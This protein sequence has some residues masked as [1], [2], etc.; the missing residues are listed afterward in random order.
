M[1]TEGSYRLKLG[2]FISLHSWF[3]SSITL[4][5]SVYLQVH[6]LRALLRLHRKEIPRHGRCDS[7]T[8][9]PFSSSCINISPTESTPLSCSLADQGIKTRIRKDSRVRK[10]PM[11]VL[12]PPHPI[13]LSSAPLPT[14]SSSNGSSGSQPTILPSP[15]NGGTVFPSMSAPPV[16]FDG[17]PPVSIPPLPRNGCVSFEQWSSD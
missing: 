4:S 1:R 6:L 7:L 13:P 8:S 3:L 10:R 17:P 14:P 11:P 9:Q 16:R 12:D 15:S 2:V 5:S